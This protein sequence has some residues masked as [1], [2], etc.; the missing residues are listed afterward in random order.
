[1]F[2]ELSSLSK[3]QKGYV[4][5][6]PENVSDFKVEAGDDVLKSYQ[7]NNNIAEHKVIAN[8][9]LPSPYPCV[10]IHS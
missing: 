4:F 8:M 1:M 6:K 5:V 2:S 7:F 10:L 3:L 9:P